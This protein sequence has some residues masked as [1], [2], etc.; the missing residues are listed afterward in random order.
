MNLQ[1]VFIQLCLVDAVQLLFFL[2]VHLLKVVCIEA[3]NN[4]TAQQCG[5][6]CKSDYSAP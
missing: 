5:G 2:F 1:S 3:P 4:S 6:I